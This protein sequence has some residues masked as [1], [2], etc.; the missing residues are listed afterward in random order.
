M[1]EYVADYSLLSDKLI[2]VRHSGFYQP[3]YG[4]CP[5]PKTRFLLIWD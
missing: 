4:A 5:L 2:Y 1:I 3:S